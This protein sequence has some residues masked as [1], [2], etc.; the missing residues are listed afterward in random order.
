[1]KSSDKRKSGR[2]PPIPTEVLSTFVSSA[3]GKKSPSPKPGSG[4]LANDNKHYQRRSFTAPSVSELSNLDLT[5][6]TKQ[7]SFTF[8]SG[9]DIKAKRG[10]Q[11]IQSIIPLR[12][13]H[14]QGDI[15]DR[16]FVSDIFLSERQF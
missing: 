13:I 6:N 15:D 5:A 2:T 1:M 14:D 4:P 3:T 9:G 10:F 16:E 11:P 8:E 12:A 7:K